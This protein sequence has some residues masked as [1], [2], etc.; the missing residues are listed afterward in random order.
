MLFNLKNQIGR[1]LFDRN[2]RHVLMAPQTQ[3]ATSSNTLV[4]SQL[5]HKDVVMYLVAIK[6]FASK[7][8]I[9]SVLILDD[10]SLDKN[11]HAILREH[12]PGASIESIER[13]R[14]KRCPNGGCWERLL[15]I[16]EHTNK[17][18]VIQLD[19]DTLSIG[20]LPEVSAA[21]ANNV[22][23]ALGTWDGQQVE[24]FL[25]RAADAKRL[26]PEPVC[27]IQVTAEK[28]FDKVP[29]HEQLHYVRGCAGFSGFARNSISKHFIEDFSEHMYAIIGNRWNEW[30]SEQLMSNVVLANSAPMTVLPHPRYA[31]CNHHQ[32]GLTTFIHF[33]GDCR[34]QGSAYRKKSAIKISE[35]I[36]GI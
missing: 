32:N 29:G 6:T 15:A 11:D 5:Q 22:S 33:I 21:A 28:A 12:I 36:Q 23:F 2:C 26:N 31:D 18:Y 4:I 30:G 10:G 9:G 16:A 13:Y 3:I 34:F 25:A 24:S 14:S 20:E 1:K 19:S 35:L 17:N 8:Q 27:H 7:V